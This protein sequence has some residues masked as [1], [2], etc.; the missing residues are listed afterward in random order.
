MGIPGIRPTVTL[1]RR[2][3]GAFLKGDRRSEISFI[4]I[5]LIT[6]S[7]SVTLKCGLIMLILVLS[8]LN[9]KR[10]PTE[11]QEEFLFQLEFEFSTSVV[12]LAL[13]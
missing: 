3:N 9:R 13:R 12:F 6:F 10:S 7:L 4:F 5:S 1:M 8:G 2:N 11:S